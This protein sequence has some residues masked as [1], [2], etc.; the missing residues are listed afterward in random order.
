MAAML[1]IA[2]LAREAAP[3]PVLLTVQLGGLV[4]SFG[5]LLEPLDV[6]PTA[7]TVPFAWGRLAGIDGAEVP[8]TSL[9]IAP[10]YASRT[11][12]GI[13]LGALPSRIDAGQLV[14][15][16]PSERR[17]RSLHIAD[18]ETDESTP[19]PLG[20]VG[21]LGS[22]TLSVSA[23]DASGAFA[24]PVVCVPSVRAK[25]QVPETLTGGGFQDRVLTLPDVAGRKLR[26]ALVTGSTPDEF[27]PVP[28]KAGTVTGWAAPIPRDLTV[29]GPDG[30][31]LWAFPGEL[32][33]GSARAE[34]DLTVGLQGAIDALIASGATVSGAVSITAKYPARIHVARP[35]I[36]GSFLRG[37][38]GTTK[39]DLDG[40]PVSTPLEGEPLPTVEPTSVV[41][42]VRVAYAGIRVAEISDLLPVGRA[43]EGVV[44]GSEPVVRS[45][46]PEALRGQRVAR[47][48]VIGRAASPADLTVQLV[49][50][51]LA[52]R[53]AIAPPAVVSLPP[54]PS[55]ADVAVVWVDLPDPVEI[56]GPVGVSV[57]ATK[58]SFLWVADP[59]P[60]IRIAVIDPDPGGR[61]I[62]L[63]GRTLLTLDSSEL[64]VG[65]AALPAPAFG[66]GIDSLDLASALFCTLELT[67]LE[68]RYARPGAT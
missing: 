53:P 46:P 27:E 26:I 12:P 21:C 6:G 41:G 22:R 33:P 4:Q 62:L 13:S 49:D 57:T 14:V 66:G 51:T 42:D 47:L 58:G 43:F 24:S 37:I 15:D 23:A 67:D 38:P 45:L 29:T 1:D 50:P 20:S 11:D 59:E 25:G 2:V 40:S 54:Q 34:I 31:V 5:A 36:R 61:P 52:T 35:Q 18:L 39:I 3:A 55:S 48:G 56:A 64:I 44:V 65:R 28:I 17:I 9:T 16:V 68:L 19:V 7:K 63:A 60:R 8:R 30:A 32:L 10:P